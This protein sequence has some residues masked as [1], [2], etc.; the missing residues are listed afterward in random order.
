MPMISALGGF[1]DAIV[2]ASDPKFGMFVA[3]GGAIALAARWGAYTMLIRKRVLQDTPT[4]LVRS[5]SQGYIE[6]QGHAEL[7][8]GD[9][10]YAPLSSRICI[11]YRYRVE[12]KHRTR[13]GSGSRSEWR[14][15]DS[16]L[17]DSLFYL[18]DATGRCAV[19]PDGAKVTA[20]SRDVWYG[21]HRV[22][23]RLAADTGWMRFT[24]ISQVGRKFRYTEERIEP[25]DPMYALGDFTTHGGAGSHFDR[26]AEV[27]E[28]LR[29]WKQNNAEM[30]GRFDSNGDGKIDLQEWDEA[31]RAAETEVDAKRSEVAVAPPV[32][33][34]GHTRG[35]RNPFILAAKTEAEMLV[36]FHWSAVGLFAVAV[37]SSV[38]VLWML[39]VR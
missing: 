4:A 38:T 24:G 9:P 14:T 23:G 21:N 20:S 33:V 36:R 29:E 8:D 7:M 10:I 30:L 28:V 12:E 25:G 16:G 27:R 17:S 26:N 2:S 1:A 11:W 19:D 34:L 18:V 13:S 35:S 31:R 39:S 6:L 37:L 32:D 22:P 5:A 3:I 15:V